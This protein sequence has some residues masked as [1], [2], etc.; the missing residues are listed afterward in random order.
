[1]QHGE[2]IMVMSMPRKGKALGLHLK[3]NKPSILRIYPQTPNLRFQSPFK[4]IA[5]LVGNSNLNLH[6]PMESWVRG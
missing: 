3:M 6:L 4:T 2:K 1:M 5:V